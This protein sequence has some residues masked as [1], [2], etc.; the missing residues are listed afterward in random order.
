MRYAYP[1]TPKSVSQ[2]PE[3]D[4]LCRKQ[5]HRWIED[6]DHSGTEDLDPSPKA[7][8]AIAT[9]AERFDDP[10]THPAAVDRT[11]TMF[12]RSSGRESRAG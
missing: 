9:L 4:C 2:R 10:E 7:R 11:E 12:R 8:A 6:G 5:R 3:S 1:N